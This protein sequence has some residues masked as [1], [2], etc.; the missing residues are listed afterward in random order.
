MT[1]RFRRLLSIILCVVIF[2]FIPIWI[3]WQDSR[4]FRNAGL[5]GLPFEPSGIL[6]TLPTSILITIIALF[7]S[8]W[9][10]R[11]RLTG[12]RV[13]AIGLTA[14]IFGFFSEVASGVL[15][16]KAY[17]SFLDGF[18]QRVISSGIQGPAIQWADNIFAGGP[19]SGRNKT[20]IGS[21]SNGVPPFFF[22]IFRDSG[23]PTVNISS[24]QD[25]SISASIEISVERG[26]QWGI[27]IFPAT[28]DFPKGHG[29]ASRP[30]G[31][32]MFVY[33]YS[34]K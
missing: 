27:E 10:G 24:N 14:V 29:I 31:N 33:Y 21:S 1:L 2:T 13:C 17:N 5:N 6:R 30:C 23:P 34:W 12:A 16:P 22:P 8:A 20:T 9:I 4:T 18:S 15:G 11:V 7:L 3:G 32:R 25:G 28:G 19:L 26:V